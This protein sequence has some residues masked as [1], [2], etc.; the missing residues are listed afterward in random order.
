LCDD[1]G[2]TLYRVRRGPAGFAVDPLVHATTPLAAIRIGDVT[3]D[4]VADIVG[5]AGAVGARAL[6]VYPQCSSRDLERC[7]AGG[8]ARA[9][10]GAP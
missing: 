5:L 7:R 10:G 6:V 2:S 3:G 1:D 4:G 8:S 9:G